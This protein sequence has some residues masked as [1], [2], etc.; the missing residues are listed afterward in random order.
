MPAPPKRARILRMPI[1][2]RANDRVRRCDSPNCA[3]HRYPA[4]EPFPGTL[5]SLAAFPL[6][7][8]VQERCRSGRAGFINSFLAKKDRICQF[9]INKQVPITYQID[10]ANKI[11][12][13]KC[14]GAVTLEDVICHFR[15]LE[16]VPGNPEQLE[17]LLDLR[18]QTSI[19]TK[20]NLLEVAD[21]I[22]RIR[23][24]V[25][26]GACAVVVS[27]EVLF[28]ML[29]MFGVFAERYFRATAVFRTLAEAEAWLA[30]ERPAISAAG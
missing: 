22:H 20:D 17:V 19:P 7:R 16:S 6:F 27:T 21:E 25:R 10:V 18:E 29:R 13:T 8:V 26:F 11:I 4:S 14:V 5:Q 12:R 15:T 24:T 30:S 1:A 23:N 2:S 9:R 28:G 3:N